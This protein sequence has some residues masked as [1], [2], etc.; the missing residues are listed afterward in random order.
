MGGHLQKVVKQ[1]ELF[2]NGR[3]RAEYV[4]P[5][6]LRIS[7]AYCCNCSRVTRQ[8]YQSQKSAMGRKAADRHD[9][10]EAKRISARVSTPTLGGLPDGLVVYE[11]K[12]ND[13]LTDSEEL[14]TQV[15]R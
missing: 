3:E 9:P 4:W 2:S 1:Q 11:Q 15:D 5:S 7:R 10:K 13:R 6:G 12:N 14:S 8:L